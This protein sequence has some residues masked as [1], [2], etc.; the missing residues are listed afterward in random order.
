MLRKFYY[1]LNYQLEK[2]KK[3]FK[4]KYINYKKIKKIL[5]SL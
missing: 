1:F 2:N 4:H 3:T 5:L